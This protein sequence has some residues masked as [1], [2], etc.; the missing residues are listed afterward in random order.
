MTSKTV[1]TKFALVMLTAAVCLL[2][3]P[4]RAQQSQNSQQPPAQTHD[5][6]AGMDMS[7][8]QRGSDQN[9]DAAKAANDAM[10]DHDMDMGAHMFMTD[11]RPANAA[12]EKRADEILATLRP[13]IAKYKD[14]HVAL[15]EG[16]QIFLPNIPQKIYH[17]TNYGAAFEARF[18]FD[19]AHPTSLLY[20]KTADGYELVGAMYTAPRNATLDDLNARVPL[21]VARWHKHVNLCF[22]PRNASL[23]QVGQKGFGFRG[24]I[25]TE[26][27]CEQAGG[28]WV[29]QIFGWMVH[30]Y[31]YESDPARVWAH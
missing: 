21:S 16:F 25:A 20:K 3:P 8:T 15:A 26:D 30:V 28:H 7:G 5:A 6:M 18:Q 11:L 23:Q 31:P 9:S 17:F 22:P 29:P 1:G 27:A 14:Y 12:D 4:A 13:A 24:S 2:T 10:S 19:A